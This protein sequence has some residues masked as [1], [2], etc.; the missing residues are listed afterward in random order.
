MIEPLF[1]GESGFICFLLGQ[2]TELFYTAIT[3]ALLNLFI[4]TTQQTTTKRTWA[5]VIQF[6]K[7][8]M[9]AYLSFIIIANRIDATGVG[10]LFGWYG[11]TR[12]LVVLW[13][14][15]REIKQVLEFV[16]MSTGIK[17]P[18]ILEKRLK[19]MEDGKTHKPE[20][21]QPKIEEVRKEIQELKDTPEENSVTYVQQGGD[22][23]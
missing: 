23:R 2:P 3:F 1:Y 19:E 16:V 11:E 22:K 10:Q 17:I 14:I 6:M 5:S 8:D 13:V 7:K 15:S 18:G 4:K 9:L 20:E 12:I 21:L